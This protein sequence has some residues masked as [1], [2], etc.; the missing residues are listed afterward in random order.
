[1]VA[2]DNYFEFISNRV[3]SCLME[4]LHTDNMIPECEKQLL[5]LEF[6]IARDFK[7]EDKVV[8]LHPPVHLKK[9]RR[10]EF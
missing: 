2:V 9:F 1:M 3:L 10:R 7:Y 6:F 4:N 5:H 8:F